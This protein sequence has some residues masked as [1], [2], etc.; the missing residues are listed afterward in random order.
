LIELI[1]ERDA[2]LGRDEAAID[3]LREA[4]ARRVPAVQESLLRLHEAIHPPP[5]NS[6][7]V[8]TD[9]GVLRLPD[10]DAVMLP[11]FREYGRWENDESQLIDLLLRPGGTFVDVGA[12][13]GYFTIRGLLRAGPEGTVVAV[14]PSPGVRELLEHNVEANVP[15]ATLARLQI[16]PVVAWDENVDLRMELAREGNTGDNRISG[17]GELETRGVRLDTAIAERHVDVVK[18]DAQGTDHRALAGMTG[19]FEVHRPHVLCEFDPHVIAESGTAPAEVLRMYRSWGYTPV[20]VTAEVVAAVGRRGP[21]VGGLPA[22]S[23]AELIAGASSAQDGF[24]T[25]WLRPPNADG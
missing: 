7:G 21:D 10:D 15:A 23:D 25:L 13:V 2:R 5:A 9:V 17:D 6:E 20:A 14:E 19:L 12:H 24:L 11:W 22:P 18:C 16:L 4:F 1:G 3:D 8:S